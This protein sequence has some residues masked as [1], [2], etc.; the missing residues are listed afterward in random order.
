VSFQGEGGENARDGVF[1]GWDLGVRKGA[2]ISLREEKRVWP[3]EKRKGRSLR[4]AMSI[5]KNRGNGKMGLNGSLPAT[6]RKGKKVGERRGRIVRGP[7][8]LYPALV[9]TG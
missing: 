1:G 9:A 3:Q 6:R 4:S 2:E 8:H 7:Q 5:R